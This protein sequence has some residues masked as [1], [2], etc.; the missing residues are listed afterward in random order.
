WIGLRRDR[1]AASA[2]IKRSPAFCPSGCPCR[3]AGTAFT[4]RGPRKSAHFVRPETHSEKNTMIDR[5]P[6]Y[7]ETHV[8]NHG[9]DEVQDVFIDEPGT[10]NAGV[11]RIQEAIY[12]LFGLIEV[13]IA[14]RFMLRA[15]GANPA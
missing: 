8:E 14:I 6:S 13:L 2:I 9:V 4:T 5:R 7:D 15:F 3:I 10:R 11:Y 1:P 12:L